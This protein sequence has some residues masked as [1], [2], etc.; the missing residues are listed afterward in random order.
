[1]L[2]F[3]AKDYANPGVPVFI[4]AS[5]MRVARLA[6]GDV[7]GAPHGDG[8]VYR[9]LEKVILNL[10][11]D[12]L[13]AHQNRWCSVRYKPSVSPPACSAGVHDVAR[14]KVGQPRGAGPRFTVP[15]RCQQF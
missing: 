13:E 4:L 9:Q 10:L 3:E 8:V 7:R 2:S 6:N 15:S 14:S 12:V 1:M 5:C 11:L